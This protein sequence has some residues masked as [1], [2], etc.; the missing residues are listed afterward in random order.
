MK[1]ATLAIIIKDGKVLLGT[2]KQGTFGEGN[3]NA[4]GGKV[5][6]GESLEECVVRETR[7]E[8]GVELDPQTLDKVATIY[9]FAG[10]NPGFE[11]HVFRAETFSGEPIETEEMRPDWYDIKNLPFEKM[12]GADR[13]WLGRVICGERI[14]AKVYYTE[15]GKGFER[16]EFLD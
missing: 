7:E 12:H 1:V 9:F 6:P 10:E 4:P 11:V 2:K 13:E 3:V 16:I 5:E 14:K 8:V 15:I